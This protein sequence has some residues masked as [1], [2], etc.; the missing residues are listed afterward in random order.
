M[1]TGFV[2]RIGGMAVVLA[3]LG[4]AGQPEQAARSAAPAP[5]RADP[6]ILEQR[7]E[8]AKQKHLERVP[9]P[10]APVAG[11]VP[12]EILDSAFAALEKLTGEDRAAFAVVRS[13]SVTWPNGALGC[14]QPGMMYTQALIPGYHVVLRHEGRDYDYRVGRSDYLMLCLD[15]VQHSNPGVTPATGA[16]SS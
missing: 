10:A 7:R 5:D 11:E 14:P 12:A 8:Q 6:A 15:P 16:P 4:C 3:A 13:E 1:V 2:V 9:A